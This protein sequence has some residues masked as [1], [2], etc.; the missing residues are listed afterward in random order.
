MA[1]DDDTGT[2][3]KPD[4]KGAKDEGMAVV[5]KAMQD[6]AKAVSTSLQGV[7]DSQTQ[8]ADQ[9]AGMN[10]PANNVDDDAGNDDDDTELEHLSNRQLADHITKNILKGIEK[11]VVQPLQENI[12]GTREATDKQA[13]QQAVEK[14]R[15]KYDDFNQWL[16]E[17]EKVAKVSPELPIQDMYLLVR[18]KDPEKVKKITEEADKAKGGGK[19]KSKGTGEVFGGLTPT[20]GQTVENSKMTKKDAAESAWDKTVGHSGAITEGVEQ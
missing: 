13:A 9:I 3:G 17:L 7:A 1:K 2:E 12:Q 14:A 11:T 16:P 6:M 5:T 20:S 18:A 19:E 8:L 10:K 15:D 4:D